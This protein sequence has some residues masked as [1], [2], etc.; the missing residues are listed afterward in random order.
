MCPGCQ[1]L[2]ILK[3][4]LTQYILELNIIIFDYMMRL[5]KRNLQKMTKLNKL[6]YLMCLLGIVGRLGVSCGVLGC[7]GGNKTDREF[8]L[9]LLDLCKVI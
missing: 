3:Q 1:G 5:M 6:R 8:W 4:N 2:F 9:Y 7:P